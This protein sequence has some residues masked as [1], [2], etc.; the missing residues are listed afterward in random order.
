M[1]G[2]ADNNRIVNF[3]APAKLINQFVNVHI[4]EAT[5]YSLRGE[6]LA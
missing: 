6:M 4:T 1:A 2:R 5:P 3:P